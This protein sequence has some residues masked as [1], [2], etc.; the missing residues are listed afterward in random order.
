MKVSFVRPSQKLNF[1]PSRGVQHTARGQNVNTSVTGAQSFTLPRVPRFLRLPRH[2][3]GL[4]SP[5]E[6]VNNGSRQICV[7]KSYTETDR[8]PKIRRLRRFGL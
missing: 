2:R 3:P 1:V 6:N 4:S 7:F 8:R 5:P